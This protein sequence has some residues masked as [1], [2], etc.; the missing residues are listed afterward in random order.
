MSSVKKA[1]EIIG[2]QTKLARILDINQSAIAHWVNRH[3]Q[4]PAKYITR[5]SELTNGQVS[6]H[7]L[8]ADH[9]KTDKES[10]A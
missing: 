10:A 3:G 5:I 4:A 7:E 9:V 8:L 6:V 2:G 1:V